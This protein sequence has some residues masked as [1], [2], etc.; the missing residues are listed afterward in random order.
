M[1]TTALE[2]NVRAFL[3]SQLVGVLATTRPDGTPRQ[4]VVYH[5]VDGDRLLISTTSAR[6]KARDVVRTGRAS[7]CVLGHERPFPSLTVEGTARIVD[8]CVGG[9]TTR[10][11]ERIFGKPTE[12][13]LTDEQCAAMDRVVV[14]LTVERVYGVSYLPAA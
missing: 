4:S 13:P 7:Y 1:N 14:E 3:D 12:T 2:P 11:F 10:L 6:A 9:P 5:V 8:T